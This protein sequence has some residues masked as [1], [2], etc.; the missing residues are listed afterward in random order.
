VLVRVWRGIVGSCT[1]RSCEERD[2]CFVPLSHRGHPP[3]NGVAA[4]AHG[5]V[6][7]GV[8][9]GDDDDVH[10]QRCPR[11]PPKTLRRRPWPMGTSDNGTADGAP[12]T[13]EAIAEEL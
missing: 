7:D 3:S 11:S 5:G 8:G 1:R 13:T 4:G 12:Q 6:C 9:A 10:G 2:T